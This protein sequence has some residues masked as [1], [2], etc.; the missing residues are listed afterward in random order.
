MADTLELVPDK[1]THHLSKFDNVTCN[2]L[3]ELVRERK[4][5]AVAAPLAGVHPST[6]RTWMEKG[7]AAALADDYDDPYC[8]FAVELLKAQAEAQDKL[9]VDIYDMSK[10][11]MQ[12]A[13]LMTLGERLYP[14]VFGKKSEKQDINVNVG[15]QVGVLEQRIHDMT[16]D[17]ADVREI[18][19]AG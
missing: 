11:T 6:V 12:W 2:K 17:G 9:A 14:T 15:V 8:E 13:G 5:M 18:Y 10:A 7:E 1:P 3:I 19:D 4:P 16:R